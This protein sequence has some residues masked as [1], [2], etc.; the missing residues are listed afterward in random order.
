[1][2]FD[3]QR[4]PEPAAAPHPQPM[5]PEAIR[6][7]QTNVG[8]F[9]L[10]I[11]G[12]IAYVFMYRPAHLVLAGDAHQSFSFTAVIGMAFCLYLGVTMMAGTFRHDDM[13]TVNA[14]GEATL[15]PKTRRIAAGGAITM[16][17]AA[18][19]WYACLYALGIRLQW[20]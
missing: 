5:S 9:L 16:T 3:A 8:I 10:G 6:R 13:R 7:Q 14:K 2:T 20:F 17:L 1:M 15:S 12:V 4:K 19:G 11:A 18:V